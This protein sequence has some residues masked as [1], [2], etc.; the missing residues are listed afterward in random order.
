MAGLIVLGAGCD[1]ASAK[2][3]SNPC[4]VGDGD[5]CASVRLIGELGRALAMHPGRQSGTCG[6]L[7]PLPA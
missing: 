7:A 3:C 1:A 2:Q 4:D 6:G 5:V